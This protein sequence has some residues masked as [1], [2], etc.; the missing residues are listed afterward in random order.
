MP[1]R[2]D[3]RQT[4]MPILGF[5]IDQVLLDD[6][7]GIER[8]RRAPKRKGQDGRGYFRGPYLARAL[9]LMHEC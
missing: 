7:M 9:H 3:E 8:E 2:A 6:Q 5:D 4:E 1:I